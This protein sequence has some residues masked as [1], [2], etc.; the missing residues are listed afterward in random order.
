M[1]KTHACLCYPGVQSRVIL[2]SAFQGPA[3]V[4][5]TFLGESA[6]FQAPIDTS[7][8]KGKCSTMSH[9]LG[10]IW[11]V[12]DILCTSNDDKK[13]LRQTEKK[14]QV[15]IILAAAACFGCFLLLKSK[16]TLLRFKLALDLCYYSLSAAVK[17]LKVFFRR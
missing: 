14:I 11:H 8:T 10:R 1:Y 9:V 15:Q 4:L 5:N 2:I 6:T 12:L 17:R 16:N 7:D 13:Y 3:T